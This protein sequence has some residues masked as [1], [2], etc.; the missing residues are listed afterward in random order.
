MAVDIAAGSCC[1]PHWHAG[2]QHSR[3]ECEEPRGP[4]M[5]LV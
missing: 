1:A 4:G 5:Q 2:S 3:V